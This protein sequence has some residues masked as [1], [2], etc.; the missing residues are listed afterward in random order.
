[1][2]HK[3]PYLTLILIVAVYVIGTAP[4]TASAATTRRLAITNYHLTATF[5][6]T[7]FSTSA[8]PG[9]V[10]YSNVDINP[11]GQI[12]VY[13]G[14][15]QP[16]TDKKQ[17]FYN[18]QIILQPNLINGQISCPIVKVFIDTRSAA[19]RVIPPSEYGDL[20][21]NEYCNRM[22]TPFISSQGENVTVT[23]LVLDR[24]IVYVSIN[25]A[26]RDDAPHPVVVAGCRFAF[27]T[28]Y[29]SAAY[30]LRSGSGLQY[31]V[32]TVLQPSDEAYHVLGWKTHWVKIN[33][34]GVIGWVTERAGYGVD[35]TCLAKPPES[36]TAWQL[37]DSSSDYDSVFFWER[38]Q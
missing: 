36:D 25:G 8:L 12:T 10:E 30:N 1:M 9:V 11:N 2:R 5:N 14:T 31:P 6:R 27:G 23:G 3:L 7:P 29:Y 28:G 15:R 38:R 18:T 24:S 16:S 17:T 26:L 33:A 19:R 13:V 22:F 35:D 37:V 34:N 20:N 21:G 4:L 32:L